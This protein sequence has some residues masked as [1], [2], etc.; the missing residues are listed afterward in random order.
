MQT[1]NDISSASLVSIV[2]P[3]LFCVCRPQN[4]FNFRLD[5]EKKNSVP[6]LPHI[7]HT[8][9]LLLLPLPHPDHIDRHVNIHIRF[10]WFRLLNLKDT[11]RLL[12]SNCLEH[13]NIL[14]FFM[15]FAPHL[16]G[17]FSHF[18]GSANR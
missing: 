16:I 4:D 10:A 17:L 1:Y 7:S 18:Y 15:Q 3:D 5:E 11:Q 9:I 2:A 6:C 12:L 8:H 13:A 14:A